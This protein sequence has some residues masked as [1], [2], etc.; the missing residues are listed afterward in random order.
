MKPQIL[1]VVVDTPVSQFFDYYP[2]K[3]LDHKPEIG[4]RVLVPFGRREVVGFIHAISH[5]TTLPKK[6]IK[7]C[8]SIIDQSPL[9]DKNTSDLIS[10][11][12]NYYHYPIGK[13]YAAAIPKYLRSGKTPELESMLF[14]KSSGK[15]KLTNHQKK[16][17]DKCVKLLKNP[18]PILLN[19]V[20]GSGK[21]ELYL[22]LMEGALKR[23]QQVLFLVPEIGLTPQLSEAITSRFG[24]SVGIIHSSTTEKSRAKVWLAAKENEVSIILGTRSSI[25]VPF[26]S[27][28]LIV[29]DEEHDESYKQQSGLLY[30][31]R[32]LAVIRAKQVGCGLILGSATPSYE[33]LLNSERGKYSEVQLNK[34]V[35]SAKP[36]EK[37]LINLNI[38]P[39]NKGLS[40]PLISAISNSLERNEQSLLFINRR[41]YSPVT[42]CEV[43]GKIDECPR[44]ESNLV[45][46]K[47]SEKLKCHHCSYRKTA[48]KNCSACMGKKITIGHGT[49]K[50]EEELE[51]R[52][53][54]E[55]IIRID[56]DSTRSNKK[57]EEVFEHAKSGAAKI[58]VGTQMLTKGHDFPNLSLVAF[59]NVDQG[60]F[61]SGYRSGERFA[62]QYYQASGRC[63]R[64]DKKSLVLLQTH[65]PN[66]EALKSL[67]NKSYREFY[68][69]NKGDR[70]RLGWPPY[71]YSVLVRAESPNENRVFDFL[72]AVAAFIKNSEGL[73]SLRVLGPIPSPI[74]KIRGRKRGQLMLTSKSRKKLHITGGRLLSFVD[75]KKLGTKLKWSIDVDPTDHS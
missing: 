11:C 53:P 14:K 72:D 33:S 3:D 39:S 57:R 70:K 48:E 19:G 34:K 27:L 9:V 31:A 46:Y 44:C 24:G 65:N 56:R 26:R 21:T 4:Q 5:E 30:S 41:G 22:Q 15:K 40:S 1:N 58:L 2:P 13:A 59:I 7:L 68:E 42:M 8:K 66:N 45:S 67:L 35:F 60:L 61:G 29:V 47:G 37:K 64:R 74:G 50:I 17:F 28:G 75:E 32:D 54:E 25:F 18:V 36:P 16:A 10:W 63:G 62:Q 71:T 52:F 12:K 55:L 49:E 51:Q 73:S 6:K 20:T 43:C 38:N 23:G 69:E